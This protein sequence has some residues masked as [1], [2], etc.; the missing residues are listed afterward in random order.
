MTIS[1]DELTAFTQKPLLA[2]ITTV[3]P[4]GSPQATPVW[5][6]YDG[7]TFWFTSH[8]GRVKVRNIRRNPKVSLVVVDTS[9]YGTP[10]IV[11]GTAEIVEEGAQDATERVSIRYEGE[12]KGRASAQ[13][14]AQYAQSIG[15]H[16]VIVRI[17]PQRIIYGE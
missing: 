11:S 9:G 13:S 12:E 6:D 2:V 3:N 16:R 10:L 17:T 5:Y 8:S 1:Q 4:D 15:R 7:E 14:L